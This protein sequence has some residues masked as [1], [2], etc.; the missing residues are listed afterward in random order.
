[1]GISAVARFIRSLDVDQDYVV[2]FQGFDGGVSFASVIGI[3]IAG[4]AGNIYQFEAYQLCQSSD[5]VNSSD[6]GA[7]Y[8]EAFFEAFQGGF[9]PLAPEPDGT[10]GVFTEVTSSPSSTGIP[11]AHKVHG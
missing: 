10:Y 9:L 5:E 7:F 6:G 3:D 4:S 11:I 2:F 1:M 8:A